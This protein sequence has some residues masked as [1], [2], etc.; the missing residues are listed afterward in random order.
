MCFRA[1]VLR[2]RVSERQAWS[3]SETESCRSNA[4]SE[5][6]RMLATYF[7]TSDIAG[8]PGAP[9]AERRQRHAHAQLSNVGY[10]RLVR[11]AGLHATRV[12]L[13]PHRFHLGNR[14]RRPEALAGPPA[15]ARDSTETRAPHP[16]R[17]RR[18]QVPADGRVVGRRRGPS[19]SSFS[20]GG[21]RFR[22]FAHAG[23]SYS[24]VRLR[25]RSAG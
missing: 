18:P 1:E 24:T 14:R 12:R 22:G 2:R 15:A 25:T 6:A 8:S 10:H 23:S 4:R 21:C 19:G 17:A 3:L 16:E 20:S 7:H 11:R 5:R 13:I 9:L